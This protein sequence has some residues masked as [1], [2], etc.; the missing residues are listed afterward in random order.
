MALYR[1]ILNSRGAAR[2]G[3]VRWVEIFGNFHKI[4]CMVV[5]SFFPPKKPELEVGARR[6]ALGRNF[7]LN[8]LVRHDCACL[9]NGIQLEIT[10]TLK[11]ITLT[12]FNWYQ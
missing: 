11:S 6:G 8:H 4:V 5:L 7:N 10:D 1:L 3:A 12:C 2:R 9:V